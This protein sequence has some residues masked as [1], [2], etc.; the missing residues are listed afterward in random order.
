MSKVDVLGGGGTADA[1]VVLTSANVDTITSPVFAPR[2]D[3]HT[4]RL[5]IPWSRPF[6][7]RGGGSK[8]DQGPISG[9]AA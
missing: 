6:S 3:S 7:A 2:V 1:H 4:C 8:L 9:V 5:D